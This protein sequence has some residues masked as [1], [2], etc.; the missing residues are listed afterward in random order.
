MHKSVKIF[1]MQLANHNS[2]HSK[3]WRTVSPALSLHGMHYRSKGGGG[4]VDLTKFFNSF[5]QGIAKNLGGE[6]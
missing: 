1:S 4:G 6:I 3:Y 2:T 5:T